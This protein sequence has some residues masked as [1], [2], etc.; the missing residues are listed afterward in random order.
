MNNLISLLEESRDLLHHTRC[1]DDDALKCPACSLESRIDEALRQTVLRND[2][3][4]HEITEPG[5][6]F[7]K[8]N[9]DWPWTFVQVIKKDNDE[10]VCR[11]LPLKS[12][13]PHLMCKGLFVGPLTPPSLPG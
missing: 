6:Y 5:Y 4:K 10:L 1:V 11:G 8:V 12:S 9:R 7:Y 2:L 3:E 13:N